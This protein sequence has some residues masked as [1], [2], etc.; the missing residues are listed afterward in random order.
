MPPSSSSTEKKEWI[1]GVNIGGW[2]L[3]ER[4]ISPYFFAITTCHLKGDFRFYPGQID[5][6]P[7]SSPIYKPMDTEECK[8]ILPYPVDEWTLTDAFEDKDILRQYL[9]IHYDNFVTRDDIRML[10]EN[11]ATHVRVPLGHWITG[12]IY[13]DEPYVNGGWPFFKRLVEWCREEG[14]QVWPDI[15]SAPGSQNGFDNSGRLL[16][17]PTC[18]GWDMDDIHA[19]NFSAFKLSVAMGLTEYK[20][21]DVVLSKNVLRSLK[22]VDDVTAAIARDNMTDVVQGLGN[23][24]VLRGT[25]HVK[26]KLLCTNTHKTPFVI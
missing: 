7:T 13:D 6:P 2:L 26:S 25:F 24:I 10:K 20:E 18:H 19:A 17:N 22:I 9:E 23:L 3:L 21:G 4:F 14:I 5:A 15:H 8:P 1:R 16:E 12:D 11:G